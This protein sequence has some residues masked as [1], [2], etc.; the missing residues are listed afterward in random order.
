MGQNSVIST[1]TFVI[2]III[3]SVAASSLVGQQLGLTGP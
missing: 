3:A 2:G 1:S